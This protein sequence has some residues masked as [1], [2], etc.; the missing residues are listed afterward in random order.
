MTLSNITITYVKNCH[1][2]L[3]NLSLT[4]FHTIFHQHLKG[5]Y[6]FIT[7]THQFMSI[8]DIDQWKQLNLKNFKV[9]VSFSLDMIK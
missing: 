3:L 1:S 8:Y 6:Y 2:I 7:F 9:I 4:L 5:I